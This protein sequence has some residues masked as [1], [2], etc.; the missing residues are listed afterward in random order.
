[1]DEEADA[2][3]GVEAPPANGEPFTRQFFRLFY[4]TT[5]VP[6][7]QMQKFLRGTGIAP[8]DFQERGW[9]S[10]KSKVFTLTPPIELARAWKGASRKG[11]ARDFDQTTFLVGGC[12]EGSN[13]RVTDTLNSPN[14]AP[15]P[16]TVDLVDWLTRH[17]GSQEIK[18]AAQRARTIYRDW[19]SQNKGKV[20]EQMKLFD[21]ELQPESN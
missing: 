13:I 15:H 10:E 9:C 6:R 1:M 7:D 2:T 3:S 11:M 4:E 5:Q 8:S 19:L 14:F 20:E 18:Y 16:A 21:L 12:I 17:G